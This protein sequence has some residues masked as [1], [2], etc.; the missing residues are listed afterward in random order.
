MPYAQ[1]IIEQ[2]RGKIFIQSQL[3]KGTEI[4]IELPRGKE[5]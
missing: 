2:H 4:K 5:N 1:K 3:G